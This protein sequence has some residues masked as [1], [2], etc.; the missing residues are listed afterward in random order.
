MVG[1][2]KTYAINATWGFLPRF[3]IF[4]GE[5]IKDDYIK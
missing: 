3:S 5:H 1:Q 2:Q 4:K